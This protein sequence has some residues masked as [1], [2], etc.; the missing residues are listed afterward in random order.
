[1]YT[2][3]MTNFDTIIYSGNDS[4]MALLKAVK[5]GFECTLTQP[6]GTWSYSPIFGW[7]RVITDD[8][9]S[10]LTAGAQNAKKL[11]SAL[12]P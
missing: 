2:V 5:C 3:V 7:R 12:M 11:A 9:Q 10:G 4:E 1:M 6:E 8:Y